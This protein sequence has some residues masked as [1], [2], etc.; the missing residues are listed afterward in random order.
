MFRRTTVL[1]LALALAA[2]AHVI[3][4]VE[5]SREVGVLHIRRR[6]TPADA[7]RDAPGPAAH[8]QAVG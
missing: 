3:G 8:K 5:G 1:A 2:S 4:Q 6:D 7:A